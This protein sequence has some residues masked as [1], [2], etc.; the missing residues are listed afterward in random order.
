LKV[1]DRTAKKPCLAFQGSLWRSEGEVSLLRFRFP[2]LESIGQNR[3]K[4]LLG[5]QGSLWRSEGEVPLLRFR[6]SG[7]EIIGFN[8]YCSVFFLG[9]ISQLVNFFSKIEKKKN[10]DC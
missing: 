6:F 7:L 10:C 8:L 1:K 3:N 9:E 5:F 2:G 4:T